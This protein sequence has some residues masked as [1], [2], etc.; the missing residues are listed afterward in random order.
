MHKV[1]DEYQ[2]IRAK[3]YGMVLASAREHIDS[4]PPMKYLDSLI[5]LYKSTEPLGLAAIRDGIF[6]FQDPMIG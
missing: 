6:K 5:H 2:R 4:L 1:G 3:V